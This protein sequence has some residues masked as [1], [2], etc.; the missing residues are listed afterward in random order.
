[1][2]QI[3][4]QNLNV[5]QRLAEI[6]DFAKGMEAV[7]S[8]EQAIKEVNAAHDAALAKAEQAKQD[9]QAAIEATKA[10]CAVEIE[11][12]NVQRLANRDGLA[13]QE[14]ELAAVTERV[15]GLANEELEIKSRISSLKT[16]QARLA[17]ILRG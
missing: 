2:P 5:L 16:E 8:I 11:R 12:I 6:Y 4:P 17:A 7:G 3:T 15:A 9:A 1:M 14:A 10:E 13:Q